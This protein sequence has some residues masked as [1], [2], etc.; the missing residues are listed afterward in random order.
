VPFTP[1]CEKAPARG[2]C[3]RAPQGASL[4]KDNDGAFDEVAWV[5]NAINANLFADPAGLDCFNAKAPAFGPTTSLTTG[6]VTPPSDGFFDVTAT[7]VGAFKD[8][9]DKWATTG[10]WVSWDSQ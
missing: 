6:A 10:K 8:A 7:Y 4:D 3:A 1:T 2:R 9:N 5:H